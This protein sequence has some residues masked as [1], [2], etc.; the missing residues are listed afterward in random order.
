M[1]TKGQDDWNLKHRTLESPGA[2]EVYQKNG[3]IFMK[4]K[5]A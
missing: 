2:I 5:G 1:K 4:I 3:F